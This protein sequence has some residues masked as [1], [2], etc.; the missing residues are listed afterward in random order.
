[1]K[2]KIISA[3]AISNIIISF[4]FFVCLFPTIR[5]LILGSGESKNGLEYVISLLPELLIL[6]LYSFIVLIYFYG[7]KRKFKLSSFDYCFLF[8]IFSNVFLGFILSNDLKISIYGFRA[9]Y[10]AMFFYFVGRYF[11]GYG[12]D[13]VTSLI[14]KIFNWF[15][16]LSVVGIVIHFGFGAVEKKMI[17]LTGH[18]QYIYFVP[19]ETSL[20]WTPVLFGTIMAITL[21]YF[22]YKLFSAPD[23]VSYFFFLLVFVSLFLSISRGPIIGFLIGFIVL[24]FIYRK[25]KTSGL[26][27]LIMIVA[28]L[29]LSMIL[30]GNLKMPIWIFTS[31]ADTMSMTEGVTRV[32]RW[33]VSLNDFLKRPWGYGLGKA[34]ETAFRF[35]IKSKTPAAVYSTDGW[36]MKMACETGVYGIVSYLIICGIYFFKCLNYIRANPATLVS[37]VFVLFLMVNAQNIVANTLDFHPYIG[38]Y[39]LLIGFSINKIEQQ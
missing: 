13:T 18:E 22:C 9:T 19:R 36:F 38:I 35:F 21:L 5:L 2:E 23:K 20:F 32:N 26:L 24:S 8:F 34:G 3:K 37:F 10:L 25:W 31:A 1:M 28:S 11:S 29:I 39:W 17:E 16:L 15:V 14:E 7:D 6:L 30:M 4:I 12:D 27:L 33:Q